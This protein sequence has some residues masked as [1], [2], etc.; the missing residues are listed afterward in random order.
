M[1]HPYDLQEVCWAKRASVCEAVHF[2]IRFLGATVDAPLRVPTVH[3]SVG[4][5]RE[6]IGGRWRW[7]GIAHQG[8]QG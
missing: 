6:G 8:G 2:P 7:L 5:K 4:T 1:A 3:K